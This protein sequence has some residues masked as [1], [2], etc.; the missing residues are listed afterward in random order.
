MPRRPSLS[1]LYLRKPDAAET[2]RLQQLQALYDAAGQ[3]AFLSDDE[4]LHCLYLQPGVMQSAMLTTHPWYL[5]C[6]YARLMMSALV[7]QPEPASAWILGQGGGSLSRF[8]QYAAPACHTDAVEIDET[9]LRLYRQLPAAPD[10]H[11][12]TLHHADATRWLPQQVATGRRTDLLL[13]DV[14]DRNGLVPALNTPDFYAS[15]ASALSRSGMLVANVWGKPSQLSV[16]LADLR[17]Q[18]ASVQWARSPDSY[19]LLV[20]AC[21]SPVSAETRQ[22]HVASL[23]QRFP[24]LNVTDSLRRLRTLPLTSCK[25]ADQQQLLED[26]RSIL[27]PDSAVPQNYPDW[28]K[29][30]LQQADTLLSLPADKIPPYGEKAYG[31]CAGELPA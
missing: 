24:S 25:D 7:Q 30:V 19:N 15:C 22:A 31:D 3:Q 8:L 18:F 29:S 14:Y 6:A 4:T 9:V 27:V 26:L 12:V 11:Q 5:V 28:K 13:I 1:T 10:N 20:F 23:E 16:M 21:Q 2:Q 17:Q